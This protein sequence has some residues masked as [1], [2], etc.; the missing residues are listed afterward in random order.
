M[1]VDGL[2][3]AK[4]RDVKEFDW[5][6]RGP[7]PVSDAPARRVPDRSSFGRNLDTL[8]DAG[9]DRGGRRGF[10]SDGKVRDF[11]NWE[12]KGPLSPSAGGPTGPPLREGGRPL[13]NEGGPGFRRNSPAWGEGRSHEGRSHEGRS[14]DGSRPPRREFQERTPTAAEMDNSWRSRMRPDQPPAPKEPSNPPSPAPAAATPAAPAAPA[15][16]ATRPRLNLQKRTVAE[17]VSSPSATGD[18]KASP[19]GGARPIDTATREKEVEER[20]QVALRQKKEAE[21]KA[22]AEKAEKQKAAKEQAKTEKPDA[23]TDSKANAEVPQGGKNFEILR[24]AGDEEGGDAADQ[25][26]PEKAAAPTEAPK[27][28]QANG[29]WRNAPA[30]TAPA[31]DDEGWSTVSSKPRNNRRGQAGRSFA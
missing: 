17:P 31:A 9:S 8:S 11:G 10:E 2:L 16:P 26:Q 21:E 19:F 28:G 18:S 4:E 15:A 27:E 3:A 30:E 22:K 5:T 23:S 13:S 7:L 25:D 24:R 6:R 12:R 14:Q 1:H 29:S 20:R